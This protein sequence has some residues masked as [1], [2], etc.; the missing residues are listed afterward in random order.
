MLSRMRPANNTTPQTDTQQQRRSVG[1]SNQAQIAA[2]GECSVDQSHTRQTEP[3]VWNQDDAFC[4][5][6]VEDN[7]HRWNAEREFVVNFGWQRDNNIEA[8]SPGL[9]DLFELGDVDLG[10]VKLIISAG[11]MDVWP[12]DAWQL[13]DVDVLAHDTLG[14]L[15]SGEGSIEA[16]YDPNG[17]LRSSIE[18]VITGSKGDRTDT[19]TGGA[20][21]TIGDGS[22]SAGASAGISMSTPHDGPTDSIKFQIFCTSTAAGAFLACDITSASPDNLRQW[23]DPRTIH[24]TLDKGDM[25]STLPV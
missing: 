15:V 21:A 20:S 22:S 6:E 10:G 19:A 16:G 2:L 1:V 4:S 25:P 12:E 11:R 8:I 17:E 9:S 13:Y 5:Q 7:P 14:F 23:Y 24:T 18:L 3:D